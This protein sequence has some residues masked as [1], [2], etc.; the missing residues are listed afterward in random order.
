M[1]QYPASTLSQK[2]MNG[3][4]ILWPHTGA[5][6]LIACVFAQGIWRRSTESN[7]ELMMYHIAIGRALFQIPVSVP[8]KVLCMNLRSFIRP[9]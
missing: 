9:T 3:Y 8:D 4:I 6:D 1:G 7:D 5:P 2:C